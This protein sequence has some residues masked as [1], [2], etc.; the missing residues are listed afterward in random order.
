MG[1]YR[2][3]VAQCMAYILA[4][5]PR[6]V[7]RTRMVMRVTGSTAFVAAPNVVSDTAFRDSFTHIRTIQTITKQLL[8]ATSISSL[9]RSL[10][11]PAHKYACLPV[12]AMMLG[13]A[14]EIGPITQTQVIQWVDLVE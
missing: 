13:A 10:P 5:W 4:R 3:S 9:A 1:F 11:I 2:E 12:A 7:R 6:K 14:R 8:L